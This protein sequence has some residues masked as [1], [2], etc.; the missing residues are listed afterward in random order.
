[1]PLHPVRDKQARQ[2]QGQLAHA[3]LQRNGQCRIGWQS[4]QCAQE[5]KAAL[6]CTQRS[7]Q[8]ERCDTNAGAKAFE[9]KRIDH[10]EG[11]GCPKACITNQTSPASAA[12]PI[13][14]KTL[15]RSMIDG[16]RYAA[17]TASSIADA[18]AANADTHC[19]GSTRR[20]NF[21]EPANRPRC[22]HM[23]NAAM[24]AKNT[25]V[26]HNTAHATARVPRSVERISSKHTP[27]MT[28]INW[29]AAPTVTSKTMLAAACVPGTP[30]RRARRTLAI[31]PPMLATG[32]SELM[33]S[34]IQ[35]IQMTVMTCGR[36]EAGSSSRHERAL[37]AKGTR[38]NKVIGMSHQPMTSMA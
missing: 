29:V 5:D 35:R 3:F 31:S 22:W 2:T 4:E 14:R 27:D 8:H 17:T 20:A 19:S 11:S 32:K 36:V 9:D 13:R 24:T 38:W 7:R 18:P 34:R 26:P 15:A 33:D 21:A 1:M 25:P 30:R 28:N 23:T 37:N 6:E 10:A 12:H 16:V